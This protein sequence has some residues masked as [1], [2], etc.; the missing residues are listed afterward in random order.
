MVVVVF[1]LHLGALS[2]LS[3]RGHDSARQPESQQVARW[4]TSPDAARRTLDTILVNDPTLF[5]VV[6]ARGFSGAAW[7]RPQSPRYQ[8]GE[9]TDSERTLAQP[10]QSLGGAFHQ[11]AAPGP[12]PVLDLMRKPAESVPAPAVAQPALRSRSRLVIEGPASRLKLAQSPA[13]KSWAHADV[14]ADSRVQVRVSPDG[15]VFSTR[16]DGVANPK[17]PV[18]RAADLHALGL[19]Q[20]LR[21]EPPEKSR[22]SSVEGVLVF[23]W[24]TMEP[25]AAAAP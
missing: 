7:L 13:L 24:H 14:L 20:Q 22:G 11:L 9:W 18:Q 17:D 4:L 15:L 8:A 23:Q 10:T 2:L 1:A 16:L 12:G 5:A 19:A 25:L 3:K 21:F 6:H